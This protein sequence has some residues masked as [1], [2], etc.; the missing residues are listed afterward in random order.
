MLFKQPEPYLLCGFQPALGLAWVAVHFWL[1]WLLC[2]FAV[3][4]LFGMLSVYVVA[5]MSEHTF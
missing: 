1:Y 4:C 5:M 3:V 2:V